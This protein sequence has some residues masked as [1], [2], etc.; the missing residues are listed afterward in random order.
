[1]NFGERLKQARVEKNLTQQQV[2]KDFF[3]TRQTISS[4]ENEASY[5]DINSLIKISDYFGISLDTLIKED[6]GMKEYLKKTEVARSLK[7]VTIILLII[8]L[9]FLGILALRTAHLVSITHLSTIFVLILGVLNAIALIQISL[10]QIKLE[11][12]K[13]RL[14]NHK[15][16]LI[17]GMGLFLGGILGFFLTDWSTVSGIASGIGGTVVIM[18]LIINYKK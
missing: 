17:V 15:A 10:L 3:I 18:D 13:P 9:I 2:A 16:T 1:M 4:W 7:P 6:N 11:T 12:K 8:D 14:T 5:P